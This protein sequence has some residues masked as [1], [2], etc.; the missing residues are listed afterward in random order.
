MIL[1]SCISKKLNAQQIISCCQNHPQHVFE[2]PATFSLHSTVTTEQELWETLCYLWAQGTT[3]NSNIII[4]ILPPSGELH[5]SLLPAGIFPLEVPPGVCL[6]GNFEIGTILP[7]GTSYGTKVYFPYS[8]ELGFANYLPDVTCPCYNLNE[9]QAAIFKLYDGAK[10][11]NLCLIGPKTDYKDWRYYQFTNRCPGTNPPLYEGLS[12]GILVVGNNCEV[13]HCEIYGFSLFGCFVRDM[14]SLN[15]T[16]ITTDPN[17]FDQTDPDAKG[18]FHFHHNY[19]HNCK[20]DGYAYGLYIS[21]GG[22]DHCALLPPGTQSCF[23]GAWPDEF[24]NFLR[25]E[26]VAEVDNNIFCDNK[27]DI[28]CSSYR[29]SMHIHNNTFSQR[30]TAENI[31]M[32]DNGSLACNPMAEYNPFDNCPDVDDFNPPHQDF[33]FSNIG[34]AVTHIENNIFYKIESVLKLTYPD[35]NSCDGASLPQSYNYDDERIVINGNYFSTPFNIV[36]ANGTALDWQLFQDPCLVRDGYNKIQI[37]ETQHYNY[38]FFG[39]IGD[40]NLEI[41]EGGP[42]NVCDAVPLDAA[43]ESPIAE[44]ASVTDSDLQQGLGSDITQKSITVGGTIWFDTHLCQDKDRNLPPQPGTRSLVNIWRF[45]DQPGNLQAEV[46][47]DNSNVTTPIPHTFNEI[48]INNVTLMT[49]DLTTTTTNDW[50]ASDLAKHLITVKPLIDGYIYLSFWIKDS[51][52]GQE[53][54]QVTNGLGFAHGIYDIT[55]MTPNLTATGFEKY[56]AIDGNIVWHE[57]IAG[58]DGWEHVVVILGAG[59]G[60]SEGGSLEIGIRAVNPVDAAIV[61]GLTFFIDD[62]YINS[63]DYDQGNAISNGDFETLRSYGT[64]PHNQVD[65]HAL[66][67][68]YQEMTGVPYNNSSCPGLSYTY[69]PQGLSLSTDEVRSGNWAYRGW[70]KPVAFGEYETNLRYQSG[71]YKAITQTFNIHTQPRNAAPGIQFN[72]LPNPTTSLSN[73]TVVCKGSEMQQKELQLF[74][75][76]GTIIKSYSFTSNAFNIITPASPGI[77]FVKL[78]VGSQSNMQKIV[79]SH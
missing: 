72:L 43:S 35:I 6:R 26:E 37:M 2:C 25:P 73:A 5:L 54:Q 16:T 10:I 64:D 42:S 47:T 40:P 66:D 77:Y 13:D 56:A 74:S 3:C 27:H 21:S 62:V 11:Q 34:G 65:K 59:H 29:T 58:D 60:I 51:Y 61:R 8:Y 28:D 53:M 30:S 4:D 67:W 45:N 15:G 14:I 38:Y 1:G 24:Y 44:I 70:I 78:T 46:R 63:P 31:H 36:Q 23:S 20:A 17:C 12:S 55:T 41:G 76:D 49:I 71:Y 75:I 50:R 69:N 7:D 52:V 39:P 79:I 57:D 9:N 19:V 18:Y 68:A 32:H 22:G 48:G 33:V